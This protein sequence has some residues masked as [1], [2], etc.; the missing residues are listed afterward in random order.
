V[1]QGRT[2]YIFNI[3]ALFFNYLVDFTTSLAGLVWP[4]V[5]FLIELTL[6]FNVHFNIKKDFAK[7]SNPKIV[8]WSVL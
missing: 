6:K 5:I 7:H 4:N 3:I 1:L 8:D 2:L